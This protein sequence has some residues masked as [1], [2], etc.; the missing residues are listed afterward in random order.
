MAHTLVWEDLPKGGLGFVV[1]VAYDRVEAIS[2]L[3]R[4]C[5]DFRRAFCE[6]LVV[7]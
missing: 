4:E 2:G 1:S 3:L 6:W 5:L 7:E